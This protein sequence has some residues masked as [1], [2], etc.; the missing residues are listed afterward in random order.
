MLVST[1]TCTRRG[2]HLRKA[3]KMRSS[4]LTVALVVALTLAGCGGAEPDEDP[5]TAAAPETATSTPEDEAATSSP[6]DDAATSEPADADATT[7]ATEPAPTGPEDEDGDDASATTDADATSEEAA[8]FPAGPQEYVSA[9][10]DAWSAGDGGRADELAASAPS[11]LVTCLGTTEG[12]WAVEEGMGDMSGFAGGE[13]LWWTTARHEPTGAELF[14]YTD[15]G[16]YGAEDAIVGA[17][18]HPDQRA[19]AQSDELPPVEDCYA[20]EVLPAVEAW[21]EGDPGPITAWVAEDSQ[22][23]IEEWGTNFAGTQARITGL[24]SMERYGTD[25]ED[26]D[27]SPTVGVTL[28]YDDGDDARYSDRVLVEFSPEVLAETTDGSVS[29]V[30]YIFDRR[31]V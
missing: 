8:Q 22:A 7:E 20:T 10:V 21:G 14:V 18:L 24:G 4:H 12:E 3:Q 2:R 30:T 23:D 19:D 29:R 5:S 17:D 16:L 27:Y 9:W 15:Q 6:V 1:L 13:G 28:T 25:S 26:E 11:T 31:F